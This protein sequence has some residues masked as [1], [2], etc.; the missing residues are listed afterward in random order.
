MFKTKEVLSMKN[1]KFKNKKDVSRYV[2]NNEVLDVFK[3][4]GH[5]IVTV[6]D[7]NSDSNNV[8]DRNSG[9]KKESSAKEKSNSKVQSND[10]VYPRHL[11][12]DNL[13]DVPSVKQ[14]KYLLGLASQYDKDATERIREIESKEE[15]FNWVSYFKKKY[16]IPKSHWKTEPPSDKQLN[17]LISLLDRYQPVDCPDVSSIKTK[18]QASEW[19]N[20]IKNRYE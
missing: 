14:I 8:L 18:K 3:E 12:Q 20:K 6:E 1:H 11:V 7:V 19:I 13:K 16:S 17:Y 2:D 9:S 10:F 15:A 4:K 5:Y